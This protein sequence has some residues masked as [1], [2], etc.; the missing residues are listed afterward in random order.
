VPRAEEEHEGASASNQGDAPAVDCDRGRERAD[1]WVQR[2]L[3]DAGAHGCALRAEQQPAV[4]DDVD[5]DHSVLHRTIDVFR[6]AGLR[7]SSDGCAFFA[8]AIAFN[9]IFAVFP[10]VILTVAALAFVYGDAE[11]QAHALA[12]INTL[13]PS[14]QGT[15]VDNLQ[16]IV[17]FRGVSGIIAVGAL[18]WSGKNLFQGTAYALNRALGIAAGRPLVSDILVALLILPTL[19][20]LSIIATLVPVIITVIVQ[21]GAFPHAAL[22][23]QIASYATAALLIFVV[24]TVLYVYLPNQRMK[25]SFG[26]PGALVFTAAWE[27]AQV[28]FAIYSAHVDYRHVYGALAAFALLLIWFYY[29]ATIFLFGAQFSA[30]WNASE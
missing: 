29:M 14:V 18:L 6:R 28:A 27:L 23:T 7:F 13:A 15:L 3:D 8:Q 25:L 26:I 9:A 24:A 5:G 10:I 21:H 11:G 30:Q 19:G 1:V 16:H 4:E 17:Q 20:V 12:L 22:V 2:R